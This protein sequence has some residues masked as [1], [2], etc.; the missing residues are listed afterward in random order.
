MLSEADS[1]TS[2]DDVFD[3]FPRL[4]AILDRT[5][6]N[7]E[8]RIWVVEGLFYMMK[9]GSRFDEVDGKLTID[10][11][12][13]GD[14]TLCDLLI[15]K[16]ALK[17][18]LFQEEGFARTGDIPTGY[19]CNVPFLQWLESE[20]EPRMRTFKAWVEA[21]GDAPGNLAWRTRRPPSEIWWLD[22]VEEVVFGTQWSSQLKTF[23]DENI[24]PADAR[25]RGA[26]RYALD[27]IR[28]EHIAEQRGE[29]AEARLAA[30]VA[31]TSP[32]VAALQW[33]HVAE[34]A[35]PDLTEDG[36]RRYN[37]VLDRLPVDLQQT[38]KAALE[39]AR[40][41]IATNIT[42]INEDHPE[43]LAA[44]LARTALGQLRGS[45][46]RSWAR[47]RST[48]VAIIFDAKFSRSGSGRLKLCKLKQLLARAQREQGSKA[49]PTAESWATHREHGFT[50]NPA[51]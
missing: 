23:V 31:A 18:A 29:E 28:A 43:G 19:N 51:F 8:H 16:H 27:K 11:T 46:A 47:A 15:Y 17:G 20:V 12:C 4:E 40:R 13:M 45:I 41:T 49:P 48:H 5:G 42:L 50:K 25:D 39:R 3:S 2:L 9:T 7:V 14:R 30:T 36:P 6:D 1:L 24:C 26:L 21:Q 37:W 34:L 44:Q 22:L 32:G 10:G 38:A 35:R 33:Q